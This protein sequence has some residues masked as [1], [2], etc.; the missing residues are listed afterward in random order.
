MQQHGH[1]IFKTLIELYLETKKGQHVLRGLEPMSI[2]ISQDGK[3]AQYTGLRSI[4]KRAGPAP[5]DKRSCQPY[6][7]LGEFGGKQWANTDSMLDVNALGVILTEIIV[8]SDVILC[9]NDSEQVNDPIT[10]CEEY[11]DKD[12]SKFLH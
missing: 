8:G 5:G 3:Q 10:R 4:A 2:Y 1:R 7:M 9:C 12:L 11:I 6:N